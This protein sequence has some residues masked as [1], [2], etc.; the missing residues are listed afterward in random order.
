MYSSLGVE[1]V[2]NPAPTD[3]IAWVTRR[4]LV[5]PKRPSSSDKN[6]SSVADNMPH[7]KHVHVYVWKQ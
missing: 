5:R 7:Y 6:K 3:G 1:R 4:R 2:T